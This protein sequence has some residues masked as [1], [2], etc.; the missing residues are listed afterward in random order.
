MQK[1]FSDLEYAAKKKLT[2]RDRFLAE[3][4]SVTPWGK[5]H[6]L[7]EPF[8][9]KVEGAGRPPIGLARMLRMYVAQQCFGLSDEGIEDAIYDSQAIRA[10]VGIDLGRESAPDATTLL[11]FRHLLEAK[12]LTQKIFEAINAHLAAK[13]VPPSEDSLPW[14]GEEHCPAVHPVRLRQSG[15]CRQAF[16]DH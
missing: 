13:G 8:Y 9:P 6:K 3:I 5:L 14:P 7:V 2:R 12:G 10:F 4:D 15:T 16:Y 11:K 1:S